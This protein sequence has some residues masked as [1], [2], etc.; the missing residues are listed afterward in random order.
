MGWKVNKGKTSYNSWRSSQ[1]EPLTGRCG[2]TVEASSIPNYSTAQP[3][4]FGLQLRPSSTAK[5]WTL[6][7]F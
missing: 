7:S 1:V 4:V 6:S 2:S 5:F 3:L